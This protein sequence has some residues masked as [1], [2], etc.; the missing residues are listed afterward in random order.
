MDILHILN[1]PCFCNKPGFALNKTNFL[2]KRC[3]PPPTLPPCGRSEHS[4]M[5]TTRGPKGNHCYNS[6][7]KTCL[8]LLKFYCLSF[9]N[10]LECL[11]ISSTDRRLGA[12]PVMKQRNTQTAGEETVHYLHSYENYRDSWIPKSK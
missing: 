6:L 10:N 8:L 7:E 2:V 9:S 5:F 12:Y 4:N 1:Y 3:K 11:I